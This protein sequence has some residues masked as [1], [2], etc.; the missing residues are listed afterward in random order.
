MWPSKRSAGRQFVPIFVGLRP[1]R[2]SARAPLSGAHSISSGSAGG[3]QSSRVF[4]GSRATH[5][6]RDGRRCASQPVFDIGQVLH[7]ERRLGL[8]ASA[9]ELSAHCGCRHPTYQHPYT[10]NRIRRGVRRVRP[11]S[12][13]VRRQVRLNGH[14]KADRDPGSKGKAPRTTR[15]AA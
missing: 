10:T 14:G 15:E 1:T 3:R 7:Q 5:R 11:L 8:S 4:H 2:H 6:D 9:T 12:D 13:R